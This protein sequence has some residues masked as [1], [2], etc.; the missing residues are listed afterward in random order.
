[1]P[2]IPRGKR[3]LYAY[4]PQSLYEALAAFAGQRQHTVSQEVEDAIRRH[5]EMPPPVTVTPP[6]EPPPPKR[7]VGRPRKVVENGEPAPKR[8]VGRPRKTPE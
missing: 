3:A 1:M 8:P 4:L 7:P 2:A 6:P 5:L